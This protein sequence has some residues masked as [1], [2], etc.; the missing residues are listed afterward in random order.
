MALI[1]G[2]V[3]AEVQRPRQKK[4]EELKWGGVHQHID[5]TVN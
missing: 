1:H 5:S 4:D 3:W 2:S